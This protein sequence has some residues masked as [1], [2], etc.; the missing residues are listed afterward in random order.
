MKK[1][2]KIT[3]TRNRYAKDVAKAWALNRKCYVVLKVTDGPWHADI[4]EDWSDQSMDHRS[5]MTVSFK[6]N[7]VEEGSFM[8]SERHYCIRTEDAL[9]SKDGT[10]SQ[11]ST[12][13]LD[14][15]ST[16][17]RLWH[18]AGGIVFKG[19]MIPK[20]NRTTF[21][22]YDSKAHKG[23]IIVTFDGRNL[24]QFRQQFPQ[25]LED[26]RVF[27]PGEFGWLCANW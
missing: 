17:S 9:L 22:E 26:V 25:F 8:R 27:K 23:A 11:L 10:L 15:P 16:D 1:K 14:V 19:E 12:R 18:F 7:G 5:F 21:C 2:G 20:P 6:I 4:E 24:P 3:R 13:P